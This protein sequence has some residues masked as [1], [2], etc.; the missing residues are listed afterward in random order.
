MIIDR[1][2]GAVQ[3]TDASVTTLATF[4]VPQDTLVYV[5]GVVLA[6]EPATEDEKVSKISAA[7]ARQDG[8]ALVFVAGSATQS[9]FDVE[10]QAAW[11]AVFNSDG[12]G[13]III[14][15]TGEAGKTIEWSGL[16]RAWTEIP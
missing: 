2:A 8:G 16:I 10:D 1:I 6:R 11:A 14:Q 4:P 15:V 9:D 13:G 12:A 5:E 7:F 3:T